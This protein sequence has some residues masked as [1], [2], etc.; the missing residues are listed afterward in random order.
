M[1]MFMTLSIY[2]YL[3]RLEY[4]Q[5]NFCPHITSW[6]EI[7]EIQFFDNKTLTSTLHLTLQNKGKLLIRA[8]AADIN[9][10]VS[11]CS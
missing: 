4:S 5:C 3:F 10:V 7:E 6:N 8:D 1:I 11:Q 9:K 2:F